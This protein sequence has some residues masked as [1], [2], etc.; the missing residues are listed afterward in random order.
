[1][2]LQTRQIESFVK[3]PDAAARVILVYGPE[4]GLIKERIKTIGL[5]IVSDLQDPFN[6]ITLSG[7]SLEEDKARLNDEAHAISMMG[8]ARLIRIEEAADKIT[9]IIKDYLQ[10]PSLE[11]LII[12]EAGDLR[13]KSTLR[14]L[15][16]RA[17]NAAAVPCYIEEDYNVASII[18]EM[19]KDVGLM[20]EPAAINWLSANLAGNRLRVRKEIEKLII[21]MGQTT[22]ISLDEAKNCCGDAGAE[23]LEKLIYNVADGQ[24]ELALKSYQRL[25]GEGTAIIAI[26]R[27]LQNHFRR[28][29]YI[30]IRLEKGEDTKE[31]MKNLSPPVFFKQADAF[32]TQVVRWKKNALEETLD[33]LLCLEADCKKTATPD[34][35]LCGQALLSIS[36]RAR[37]GT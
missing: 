16:E 30:K 20:A 11:N 3:S 18:R 31:A 4:A 34:E 5:T 14:S 25:L 37:K 22:Q 1:M 8:G 6:N 21:Y 26:L 2:K 15:C 7:S 28:L 12:L 29:H 35:T 9:P 36:F 17:K 27:A 19:L 10:N 33:K 24:T 13:P 32:T 23:T